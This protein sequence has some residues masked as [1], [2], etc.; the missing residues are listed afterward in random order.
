MGHEFA[1]EVVEVGSAL[2]GQWRVGERVTAQPFIGCGQCADC[3]AGQGFRCPNAQMRASAKLPGAYAEYTRIGAATSFRLPDGVSFAEGALVEPLA[4]GLNA[5][6]KARLEPGDTV[7]IVGAGPVG[8]AVALWCRFL[9]ARHI[10]ISDLIGAR[11]ERATSFGATAAI[12]ASREDVAARVRRLS[13][14]APQ[15]VFDCVGVPG[16]FQLA[17][18]YAPHDAR[19]VIVGLCMAA[20]TFFPAKA[21]TKELDLSFAFIYKKRDFEIVLDLLGC[22]RIDPQ[23]MIT[24]RVGFD[25]F[26]GAFDALKRPSE[27]IKVMLEPA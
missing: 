5:V 16:S 18:D 6:R 25:D 20:D 7:L 12:D 26:C 14:G 10:V 22:G 4:V 23:G 21:L 3:L 27:Q 8:I 9:G 24:E 15:V 1:G 2:R 17:I 11:A 13:G 19:V